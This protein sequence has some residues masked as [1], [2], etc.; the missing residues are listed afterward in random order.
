MSPEDLASEPSAC[1]WLERLRAGEL[2]ARELAQRTI[3]R[4]DAADEAV[5][6]VVERRD[7]E[8]LAAAE[9]ADRARAQRSRQPL[10]GLPVTIKDCLDVRGWRTAAGSLARAEHRADGDAT[11]VARLR[12][13]GA[14]VVAKTNV[15]EC[16]ASFETDNVLCGR[17]L[18]PL[19]PA[20][21]PGGSSGGEAALLGADA[22]IVGI[23]TDGGGSIRVPS[24]YCGLVGIRPTVGRTPETGSW[25]GTRA[26]GT[27]D[28]TCVGPLGRRVEDL[29]LLLGAIAGGD[30]VDPYAVD[31]P[32]ARCDP[33]ALAGLRV[34]FYVEHPRVPRTTQA[35]RDAVRAAAHALELAGAHVEEMEPPDAGA[36]VEGR[37][38]TQLFF[39]AAGA[40][41]GAALRRAVAGA[42][43]R[44]HPQFLALLGEE[45]TVPPSAETFFATQRRCFAYRAHVRAAF[46]RQALILSPVVAGPAPAHEQPP[47]GIRKQEYML[48]EAFEYVH[49]NAVAGI[50]AASVPVAVEDGLPLGVQLAAA[51]Y[52]EDRV[53]AAAAALEQAFGGFAI[54]RRLALAARSSQ[55]GAAP[56]RAARA[57]AAQAAPGPLDARPGAHA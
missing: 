14:V 50:P 24:H 2:S 13:A 51:P 55:T 36:P 17:T 21:T 49:V 26:S 44:H 31:R 9:Q 32:L 38:A 23:G 42:N 30:G 6:A 19:A 16:C 43:G 46:E 29:E 41:G 18:N 7:E 11:V 15:P 10:L 28:F 4:I 22:S 35:T 53:L 27:M 57:D 33:A 20:H 12:A 34:G 48:Y 45:P 52:R 47:A 40:D 37:S 54:N 1:E 56:A 3:D 39:D 5:N 25:P 8:A